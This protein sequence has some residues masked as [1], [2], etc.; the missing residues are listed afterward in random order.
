MIFKNTKIVGEQIDPDAYHR[1]DAKR[2]DMDFIMSKSQLQL[3][4]S[5]PA[6]WIRGYK[7]IDEEKTKSLEWGSLLDTLALDPD[8]FEEKY[9]IRPEIYTNDKGQEKKWSGNANACKDWI[10]EQAGKKIIKQKD[11]DDAEAAIKRLAE[12]P[13][14]RE[15]LE[16]SKKQVMI[17][18]EY[19]DSSTGLIVP[20]KALLDM[21]MPSGAI[22]DLKTT[23]SAHPLTWPK[24]IYNYGYHVQGAFYKDLYDSATGNLREELFH[25]ILSENFHPW[26]PGKEWLSVDFEQIGREKY[27]AALKLYCQCLATKTWP[28]YDWNAEWDGWHMA[29]PEA[30][31]VK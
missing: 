25:F 21:L 3:F 19:H 14:I 1:Q 13:K 16:T 17:V 6:R 4:I 26:E 31:M 2:G 20:V 15:I 18:G 8:R 28:G 5:C 29:E 30:W 22:I 11:L 10:T 7:E 23:K 27:E 24:E 9:V 12:D